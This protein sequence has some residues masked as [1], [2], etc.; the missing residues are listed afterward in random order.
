MPQRIH[1]DTC[2]NILYEGIELKSPFE[3][4]ELYEGKCPKC[5]RRLSSV[6]IR[7][8]ITRIKQV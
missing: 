7:V 6:P 8:N 4:L 1:C 5:D 2:G 3:I